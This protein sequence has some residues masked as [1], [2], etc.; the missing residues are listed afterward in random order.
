MPDER[1][2]NTLFDIPLIMD[3]LEL[4]SV[5]GPVV[6][7]GCGYGTFTVPVAARIARHL[8]AFD[9][10]QSMIAAAGSNVRRAG[11]SNVTLIQ[12]DVLSD[13]TGLDA[14]SASMVLLFN[15]LHFNERRILLE[16][17]ARVLAPGGMVAIIHWRKDILTPRGPE[18]RSRPDTQQI[19]DSTFGLDL[20]YEGN[21]RTLEPYHWGMKLMK[22]HR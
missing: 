4:E 1:Y 8:Y 18:N 11:L 14:E 6:E 2:W 7:V 3:W 19:L 21:S 15:I 13:G 17:A 5:G 9:I 22:G 10:E 20:V 12:R 16:E